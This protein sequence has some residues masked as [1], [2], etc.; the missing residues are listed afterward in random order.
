MGTE[1]QVPV[2]TK[3]WTS[4]YGP[5]SASQVSAWKEP[6]RTPPTADEP[7][8]VDEFAV[9]GTES[10][11]FALAQAVEQRDHQTSGHCERLAFMAV[12]LGMAM[13]FD[14]PAL[15]SLYRGGYLHDVGKVG[16]PDS[17][18]FKTGK[19][20]ADEWVVMRSH[21]ARGEE[22]CRPMA[23]L[24]S[25]LPLIRYH[26]ERWDGSGYPDGLRGDQIPLGARV[27]Q[28]ADIYDALI[29]PRPYK[30]AYS[31]EQS[32]QILKREAE[33]GW[34]DPGV[35]EMFVRMH[36][37]VIAKISEYTAGADRSLQAMRESLRNLQ[38]LLTEAEFC[39]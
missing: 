32:L 1:A 20:T 8:A 15:L 4:C 26:H 17:I 29:S 10:I 3:P 16:I 30:P 2:R 12:S 21:P 25:V 34:R 18:L 22:I 14:R 6:A 31:P 27:L 36:D 39:S 13:R 38:D 9:D 19:L 7:V 11:L 37:K 35:V 28:V 24:K 23:S 33:L 5:S